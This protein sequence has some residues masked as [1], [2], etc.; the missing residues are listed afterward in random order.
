[1][2]QKSNLLPEAFSELKIH[3]N[4]LAAGASP[5]PLEEPTIASPWGLVEGNE[6][7]QKH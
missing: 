5:N 1:M 6:D 3:L 2:N 4:A 7:R